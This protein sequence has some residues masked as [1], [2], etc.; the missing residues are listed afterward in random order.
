MGIGINAMAP[1]GPSMVS[2][3][4]RGLKGGMSAAKS[5]SPL[6]NDIMQGSFYATAE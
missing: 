4:A 5:A 6:F 1:S 3:G 2:S